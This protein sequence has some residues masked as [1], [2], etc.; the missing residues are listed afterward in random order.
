MINP[1]TILTGITITLKATAERH[2]SE[3]KKNRRKRKKLAGY[4]VTESIQR[5]GGHGWHNTTPSQW[6]CMAK[7]R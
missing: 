6:H 1:E 3:R 2:L 5:Q 7:Q 4:L